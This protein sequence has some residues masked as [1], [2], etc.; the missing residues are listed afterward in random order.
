VRRQP[1]RN[2]DLHGYVPERSPV[3]LLLVDVINAM[4][5]AGAAP[6]VRQAVRMA[7]RIAAL[8]RRAKAAAIPVVYINDNFGRWQSD[9]R[10]VVA[11][12]LRDG[13]PGEPVARL[14]QPDDD[15]YFVLKPKHSA[16]FQTTLDTLLA[17]L[18]TRTVILAGIAGN[19]CILFSANDA[20]M[21]DYE[22]LVP[23]DCCVSNTRREND[24]ALAQIA[25]VL[26]ADVGPSTRI[27]LRALVRRGRPDATRRSSAAS[28]GTRARRRGS[29]GGRSRRR[30]T[31]R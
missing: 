21:R 24:H 13:V 22:L 23:S 1:A 2:P 6:L 26:K 29:R 14:L 8:K 9:F 31:R 30:R 27:D 12:C 15:D 28:G 19:I 10:S 25:Q 16:F 7:P 20:Y 4:D 3:A 11:H 5:F 18:G 17:Y